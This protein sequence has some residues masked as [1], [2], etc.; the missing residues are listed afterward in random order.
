MNIEYEY[1]YDTVQ[2]YK[3]FFSLK[4]CLYYSHTPRVFPLQSAPS[5]FLSARNPTEGHEEGGGSKPLPPELEPP[6]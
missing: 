5:Q 6:A 3:S 4:S 2:H 1:E